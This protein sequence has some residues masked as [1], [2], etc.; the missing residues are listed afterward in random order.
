M[1]LDKSIEAFDLCIS[2][3]AGAQNELARQLEQ[4]KNDYSPKRYDEAKAEGMSAF[5]KLKESEIASA[6]STIQEDYDATFSSLAEAMTAAP[7]QDVLDVITSLD[8]RI[9]YGEHERE[10]L[11]DRMGSNYLALRKL[12]ATVEYPEN[13][14]KEVPD[15]EKLV[16]FLKFVENM[17]LRELDQSTGYREQELSYNARLLDS[18][19]HSEAATAAQEFVDRF[20]SR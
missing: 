15:Y 4:F 1:L 8:G 2:T 13:V 19:L 5:K 6:T 16:E 9:K 14:V 10:A 7:S 18:S 17:M 3:L 12:I 20:G 11:L